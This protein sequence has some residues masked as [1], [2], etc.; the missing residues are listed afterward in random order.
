M[1]APVLTYADVTATFDRC[2][3]KLRAW[4]HEDAPASDT[5]VAETLAGLREA[6]GLTEDLCDGQEEPDAVAYTYSPHIGSID[7]IPAEWPVEELEDHFW[8]CFGFDDLF[9][10]GLGDDDAA[11]DDDLDD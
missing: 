1:A 3:A 5:H 10:R 6:A 4:S 2:Y 11:G 7:A 8:A 9:P